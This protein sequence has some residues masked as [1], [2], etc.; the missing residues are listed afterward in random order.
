V[1]V[2]SDSVLHD[3]KIYWVSRLCPSSEVLG[4]IKQCLGNWICFRFRN[5]MV[6]V[7]RIPDDGLSPEVQ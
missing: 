5:V 1:P 7:L 6:P 4:T 2:T 3:P